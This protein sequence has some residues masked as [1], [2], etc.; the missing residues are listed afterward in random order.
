MKHV[1]ASITIGVCLLF[2]SAGVVFATDPHKFTGAQGEPGSG[3]AAFGGTPILHEGSTVHVNIL[4]ENA[5]RSAADRSV[6]A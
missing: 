1:I 2:P 4:P 5:S 3:A 6:D